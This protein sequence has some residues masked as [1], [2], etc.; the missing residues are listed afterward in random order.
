MT[1]ESGWHLFTEAW[2]LCWRDCLNHSPAFLAAAASWNGD[3]CLAIVASDSTIG[4]AVY[5]K[6]QDG[7][8]Q[9]ARSAGPQDLD[10]ATVT[11][12]ARPTT[13]QGIFS[14]TLSPTMAVFT[15]QV[16]FHRGSIADLLPHI[17]TVKELFKGSLGVPTIFSEIADDQLALD[18]YPSIPGDGEGS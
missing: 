15:G 8:C 5:L 7:T 9:T 13:W 1:A 2:A 18:G 11:L 14:G 12:T 17:A 4:R 6:V 10:T 16:T 3:L